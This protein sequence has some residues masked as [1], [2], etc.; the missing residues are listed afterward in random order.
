MK[1][2]IPDELFYSAEFQGLLDRLTECDPHDMLRPIWEQLS[3]QI[4]LLNLRLATGSKEEI[5][6]TLA[7]VADHSSRLSVAAK[8]Y[9]RRYAPGHAEAIAREKPQVAEG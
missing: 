6:R 9:L 1:R 3:D 5:A 7:S 8:L 2:D 4:E